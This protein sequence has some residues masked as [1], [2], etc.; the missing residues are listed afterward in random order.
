MRQQPPKFNEDLLS[1]WNCKEKA[2][3]QKPH[4]TNKQETPKTQTK[5][6]TKL[7]A[8]PMFLVVCKSTPWKYSSVI[9]YRI[10]VC[11]NGA[12][13][14]WVYKTKAVSLW[15]YP[16]IACSPI[17]CYPGSIV[18]TCL[19]ANC[20]CQRE[21][22][23]RYSV[24]HRYS[25]CASAE[26]IVSYRT[27]VLKGLYTGPAVPTHVLLTTPHLKSWQECDL[28]GGSSQVQ[29]PNSMLIL[30]RQLPC[31]QH[32]AQNSWVQNTACMFES[33]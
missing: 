14:A 24:H 5:Q 29:S 30:A 7:R 26:E 3:K 19:S 15:F 6:H 31:K 32:H 1:G 13:P 20:C 12:F 25:A 8:D 9:K 27:A 18:Y 33:H 21:Q 22:K 2:T 4:T 17:A 16:L 11:I 23:H 10:I 28:C